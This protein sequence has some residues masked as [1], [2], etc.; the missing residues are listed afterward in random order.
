MGG[1]SL[2]NMLAIWRV[3]E[4]DAILR[5][6]WG[7]G[8]H[9]MADRVDAA[10]DHVQQAPRDAVID[11]LAADSHLDQLRPRHQTML[12]VRPPRDHPIQRS[13]VRFTP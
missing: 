8:V 3:H 9:A 4:L 11:R 1:G 12:S 10:M 2:G 5:E 13:S 7:R 6:C